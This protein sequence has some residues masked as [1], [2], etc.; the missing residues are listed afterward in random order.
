VKRRGARP[1]PFLRREPADGFPNV[2][3]VVVLEKLG[4]HAPPADAGIEH[5]SMSV[6]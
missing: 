3:T 1:N 4:A 2:L 5:D 6:D